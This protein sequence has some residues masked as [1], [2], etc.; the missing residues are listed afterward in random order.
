M[1]FLGY[2][3][4]TRMSVIDKIKNNHL[5]LGCGLCETIDKDN[6]KMSLMKDG[7]YE[8][9]F[10]KSSD[11]YK[12]I[13]SVCPGITILANKSQ[14]HKSIWGD[15]VAVSNAWASNPTIR[16]NSSSG[17]VT[18]ALAIYLLESKLVD[19][20]LHVGVSEGT[21]LY[22]KLYISKTREEVLR[23][24]AS[25]YAPA[26]VFN[27]IIQIFESTGST[28]FA[29]IGKPCDIAGL[30][31]LLRV[32]PRYQDRVK[33][34]LS[35]FCA[36]MPTYNA[37]KKAL[38]TFGKKEEPIKLQ[39]RGDGWPGYFTATYKD[40][41][42]CKMTY[43]ESWGKIL[44]RSLGFRCKICPD[45]IGMLA[46]IASGD[47][48]NTKDGYPDFTEGD[49]R[50]FCFIRNG[51]GKRLFDNA[52]KAGYIMAQYLDVDDVKNMQRYQYERRHV[53]GWRIAAVQIMTFGLLNFKGL[54]YV[55]TALK[56]KYRQ[57]VNDMIG[58]MKRL[59]KVRL[60]NA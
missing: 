60:N 42:S 19:A 47:S 34:F 53:V 8:P 58:T 10:R 56:A 22:N 17:G 48:W 24:N 18:S 54:G 52:V 16:K 36:G 39:Y 9:V 2:Q 55:N 21:Y 25:R 59:V 44:G 1:L 26:A 35:I 33:F 12:I 6:C 28:T 15:V 38:S 46:D 7:F 27:D 14:T 57:G 29:F 32:Y 45:G 51:R 30:Q 37:S 5:C 43:N 20:I 41:T 23:H 3:K 49:G 31:N 13:K 50:N 40:G 11:K 4:Y